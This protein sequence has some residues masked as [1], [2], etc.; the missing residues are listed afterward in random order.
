M[1][2]ACSDS[3]KK[4]NLIFNTVL[5]PF[6]LKSVKTDS[7]SKYIFSLFEDNYFA[8][9]DFNS[10]T[11]DKP[12]VLQLVKLPMS[13]QCLHFSTSH[14]KIF[15]VNRSGSLTLLD[16]SNPKDFFLFKCFGKK[17][18]RN[19]VLGDDG[20]NQGQIAVFGEENHVEFYAMPSCLFFRNDDRENEDCWSEFAN[21]KGESKAESQNTQN[22]QESSLRSI[23][24]VQNQLMKDLGN[25]VS[26]LKHGRPQNVSREFSEDVELRKKDEELDLQKEDNENDKNSFEEVAETNPNPSKSD[27]QNQILNWT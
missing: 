14:K 15:L 23:K 3:S 9:F 20:E 4:S 7:K 25:V 12:S 2:T 8:I 22:N 24:D 27:D 19:V 17:S 26:Q 1:T 11:L 5:R 10:C 6:S 18:I 16:I 13:P 21:F